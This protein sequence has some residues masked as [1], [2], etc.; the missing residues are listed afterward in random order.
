MEEFREQ[1]GR[2]NRKV[3]LKALWRKLP[4]SDHYDVDESVHDKE[5]INRDRAEQL[6]RAYANELLERCGNCGPENTSEVPKS[7]GWNEF[8]QYAQNKEVGECTTEM[9]PSPHL[10]QP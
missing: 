4:T 6:R 1:E 3:R 2:E 7:I 5:P 10:N 8:K 9:L